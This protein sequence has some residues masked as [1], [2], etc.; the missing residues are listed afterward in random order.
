MKRRWW[1]PPQ[2]SSQNC[3]PACRGSRSSWRLQ[4]LG[5]QSA[6]LRTDA[7]ALSGPFQDVTD[8]DLCV[9]HAL[10][11]C[12][13]PSACNQSEKSMG[14]ESATQGQS[15]APSP[16]PPAGA[17]VSAIT[18]LRTLKAVPLTSQ[19][20]VFSARGKV[21]FPKIYYYCFPSPEERLS[22]KASAPCR[23]SKLTRTQRRFIGKAPGWPCV[24]ARVS[25]FETQR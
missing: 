19:V 20:P 12:P 18:V 14:T 10:P 16:P 15:R 17:H 21:T 13:E 1:P 7:S 8:C 25:V 11:S 3:H 9:C 2:H 23:C 5:V 4:D 24:R 22:S 6:R